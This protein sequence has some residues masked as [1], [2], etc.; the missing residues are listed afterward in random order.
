MWEAAEGLVAFC[1]DNPSYLRLKTDP[2]PVLDQQRLAAACAAVTGL[3]ATGP[4]R[5][6]LLQGLLRTQCLLARAG[7]PCAKVQL[8]AGILASLAALREACLFP[9]GQLCYA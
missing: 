5:Q 8:E 3:T 6:R 9:P 7:C 2:E 1:V 4:T